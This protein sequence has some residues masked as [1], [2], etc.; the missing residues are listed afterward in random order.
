MGTSGLVFIID[1]G[2]GA[3]PSDKDRIIFLQQI[4]SLAETLKDKFHLTLK[5]SLVS[6]VNQNGLIKIIHSSLYIIAFF[7]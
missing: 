7:P 2:L 6:F 1:W 4:I 3:T 5:V